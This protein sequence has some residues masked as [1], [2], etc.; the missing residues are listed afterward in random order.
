[1]SLTWKTK[2]T[3]LAGPVEL[4]ADEA[5]CT[6]DETRLEWVDDTEAE[7]DCE[8]P[9][10]TGMDTDELDENETGCELGNT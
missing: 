2:T 8:C 7:E 3:P 6:L 9:D 10:E 4:D 5:D 1:M